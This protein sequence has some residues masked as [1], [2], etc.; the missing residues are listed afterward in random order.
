MIPGVEASPVPNRVRV[1]SSLPPRRILGLPHLPS[2]GKWQHAL[3]ITC[4]SWQR[5][6]SQNELVQ[7]EQEKEAVRPLAHLFQELGVSSP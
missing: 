6:L 1:P 3:Q 5:H 7:G 2:P 4:A